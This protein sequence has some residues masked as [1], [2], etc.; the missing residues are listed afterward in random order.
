MKSNNALWCLTA[1]SIGGPRLATQD[2]NDVPFD[3]TLDVA[4]GDVNYF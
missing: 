1:Y 3:K 2:K 4:F